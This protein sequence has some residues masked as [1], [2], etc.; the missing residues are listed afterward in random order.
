MERT[1]TVNHSTVLAVAAA[2]AL[3]TPGEGCYIDATFGGGGHSRELLRKM[4]AASQLIALDCDEYAEQQAAKVQDSRFRFLRVNFS[5]L[6]DAAQEADIKEVRGVLFDLGVSSMQLDSAGRGLS[7]S[8]RGPLDMRLDR[9]QTETAQSLIARSDEREIVRILKTYGEE[10]EA[11]RVGRAIY[12]HRRDLQ[13]TAALARLVAE[14]KRAHP[15]GRHPAT[16]VFQGLRIAVNRELDCLR[17]G[18]QA[19][20]QLLIRGGRLVVIAFHSLEDRTVKREL[21]PPAYPGTGRVGGVM[22][23]LGKSQTPCA[24]EIAANP[25]ARSARMRV[26]EKEAE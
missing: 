22:R 13:D 14:N 16:L 4:P 6:A 18:L 11:R 25:R 8:R 24:D 17:R 1:A 21:I 5:Q 3:L 19:A 10:P 15:P 23:V 12:A 2:E 9:R 7:F 20:S 26:F